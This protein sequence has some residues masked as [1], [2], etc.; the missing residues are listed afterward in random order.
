MAVVDVAMKTTNGEIMNI[1]DWLRKVWYSRFPH[2]IP[3]LPADLTKG[4]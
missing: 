1:L 3:T 4:M 2:L